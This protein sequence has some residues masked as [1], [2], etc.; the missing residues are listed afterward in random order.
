LT[1]LLN[2]LGKRVFKI[3]AGNENSGRPAAGKTQIKL[4]SLAREYTEKALKLL[5]DTMD[6]QTIAREVRVKAASILLDRGWGK[7]PQEIKLGNID[8]NEG[9]KFIVEVV[10][11]GSPPT[12]S[13]G[14]VAGTPARQPAEEA[15]QVSDQPGTAEADQ[16]VSGANS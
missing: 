10:S 2:L 12:G 4:A 6:D 9:V 11:V 13:A 5:T 15:G 8:E 16:S 7:A 3:V 1:G 14:E